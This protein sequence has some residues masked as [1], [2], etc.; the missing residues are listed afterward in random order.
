MMMI[1]TA[2]GLAIAAA[3]LASFAGIPGADAQMAPSPGPMP[4]YYGPQAYPGYYGPQT[5]PGYYGAPGYQ[6]SA[7]PGNSYPN[8]PYSEYPPPPAA[9]SGGTQVVT[10]GPQASPGDTSGTWS[11]QRNVAESAHYDRLLETNPA[12]RDARIRRECGPI[13][14]PTLRA[15]CEASFRQYE[16]AGAGASGYGSSAGT[17]QNRSANG[18]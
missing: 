6:G 13:T 2:A 4:G 3:C 8:W 12:F 18:R 11:A 16:T 5:Y 10:N 14:D 7:V 1:K 17:Q 15:N 9:A